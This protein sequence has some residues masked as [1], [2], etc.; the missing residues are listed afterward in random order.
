MLIPR[1]K[2]YL[3]GLN[4][5]YLHL[6]KF[7]EHMQGDIGSG[8]IYCKSPN[9][10]LFIFFSE[11]EI[12]RCLVQ[13]K[14]EQA[15]AYPFS[16]IANGLFN[17]ANFT[18]TVYQLASHAIFFWAQ[19]PP[20]QRAKSVLKSTEIQLS[21]LVFRLKQKRF[22]GFIDAQVVNEADNGVLFFHEGERIGG[23]YTWGKGGMSTSDEDYNI[24]LSRIQSG[25]GT[26]TFGNFI[27]E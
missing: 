2:P 23:S 14:G 25:E 19:M 3:D 15:V 18:V 11:D 7:I 1:E 26:F 16:E 20:F 21:D 4:N 13:N 6:E 22:S 12:I 5:Y 10:E 9:L 27:N 24:L 8:G 17:Q